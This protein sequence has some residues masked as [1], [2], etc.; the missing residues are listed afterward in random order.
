MLKPDTFAQLFS[1]MKDYLPDL[2]IREKI[3]KIL[4]EHDILTQEQLHMHIQQVERMRAELSKL[5]ERI[6]KIENKPK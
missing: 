5:E 2:T 6:A 4:E 1:K 3:K